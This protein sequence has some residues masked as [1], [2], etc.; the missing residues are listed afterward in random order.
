VFGVPELVEVAERHG[1]T[2]AQ[3]SL[4]WLLEKGAVPIPKASGDH[5]RANY[6]AL[7]VDLDEDDVALIDGIEE[8][9][10]FVR[11]E[12]QDRVEGNPWA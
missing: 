6:A 10:R 9:T 1:V 7:D 5:I 8:E 12:D 3:V 4:A 2:E 11:A